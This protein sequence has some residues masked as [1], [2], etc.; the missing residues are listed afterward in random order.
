M[1]TDVLYREPFVPLDGYETGMPFCDV[2]ANSLSPLSPNSRLPW[3]PSTPRR[4]FVAILRSGIW[5]LPSKEFVISVGLRSSSRPCRDRD[6]TVRRR[7]GGAPTLLAI[8]ARSRDIGGPLRHRR[9]VRR[10]AGPGLPRDVGRH[11][12]LSLEEIDS[13]P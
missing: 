11:Q 6:K 3:P 5:D 12:D 10:G 7:W 2:S 13:R 4:K 1:I 9:S 8:S